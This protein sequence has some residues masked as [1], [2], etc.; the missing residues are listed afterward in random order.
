MI[1]ANKH[2]QF[3]LILC[4]LVLLYGVTSLHAQDGQGYQRVYLSGY[5]AANT[6]NWDFMMSEGRRSDEWTTIPVPSNW[7]LQGF[8]NYNYGHDHDKE[9]ATLGKEHGLY[10]H[11]FQV[12]H[13]WKGKSIHI[14]FD[15]AMTDTKVRINGKSAGDLHQGGF[16]RFKYDITNLLHYGKENLLEVDVAKHSANESVNQAEREADFWILG[17]IFRPVYLEV[18][19][20]QHFERI[21]IDAKADGAFTAQLSV[22]RMEP[23]T[24]CV[25]ELY[26]LDGEKVGG[27]LAGE[28][29]AGEPVLTLHGAFRDIRP[30][31]P[32]KPQLYTVKF[33]LMRDN[34]R[35]YEKEERIGFR[36]VELRKNNGFY[37]NGKKVVFKGV[38][39]HSFWPETGRALSEEN[40]LQDI[41]LIK[42]M[43]MNAVRMSHYP[44]DERF[45][46]LC[47]SLGLFVLDEVTG[48]QAA[49]D[50]IVGPKLIREAVLKDENHPSVVIWD[51]GNEGGWDF[52]NEKWF[53]TYDIQ[54]RPVI[55]P[56]L[57]R[58][59]VDT[60]HYPSYNYGIQR[61]SKGQDVFMPTEFM[62]GLYDGGHGA[63]LDDFWSSYSTSPLFAGGFLWVFSDEA[64]V[65]TDKGNI[66]D[67]DG[68]HA[69]D[70][71]LG[72][73]R[74]KE[75]SFYTIREIWSPV[76]VHP[77]VIDSLF[78]GK[79]SVKNT[80]LYTNLNQCTFSWSICTIDAWSDSKV[81]DSGTVIGP[82]LPP[83]E[84]GT[85]ALNLPAVLAHAELLTLTAKNAFGEEVCTWNWPIKRPQTVAENMLER[86]RQTGDL[87]D[88]NL[89]EKTEAVTAGVGPLH[90][91]FNKK[92]GFLEKVTNAYGEVSFHGGPLAVGTGKEADEEVQWKIDNNGDFI[93]Q[94]KRSKYPELVQWKLTQSGLL[95]L[96]VSPLAASE[97]ELDYLGVSFNYPESLVRAVR[98]FGKGPYR[99][100]KNRMKGAQVAVWQKDY[101]NTV[102]GESYDSLI[103]PEFKGYHADLY[104]MELQTAE[105]PIRIFTETPGLFFR[106]FTP[107]TPRAVAGGVAPAFPEGDISFLHEIPAIGTKFKKAEK[108]GP[109]S[110]KGEI[111]SHKGDESYPISL[112]F[113][114]RGE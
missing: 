64:I 82:N 22:N 81:L 68:N 19:P 9:G 38:N 108:M 104:W 28:F 67:S 113:D 78:D 87:N 26:T 88:V 32:E 35:L 96:K 12:P 74:E 56:W 91:D 97:N 50:T 71:I 90:F 75:G 76:Q 4:F 39:R 10:K 101:N 20:E 36:T 2:L 79:L 111:G 31:N 17:G 109:S 59:G 27:T 94:V 29:K 37:I 51:H 102:T 6:V 1:I 43:N 25:V 49:Y 106:L 11:H 89:S 52:A 62:H 18:L 65:R 73:Y 34:R 53:H 98:W 8:G 72:P 58:N 41:R 55:Y 77:L 7:E 23:N 54:K 16:Y 85:I 70:G 13:S 14:V 30:W 21:A 100:W 69:P 80:Y 60:Y 99:V 84:S 63:G 93:L 57:Q 95:N 114:F 47:D 107:P 66:L 24:S 45:L 44:P 42:E 48:W 15:G 40:H 46:E 3:N 112:W 83:G 110:Q 61:L 92:N 5:D 86:I 105:T 103:Y 33:S